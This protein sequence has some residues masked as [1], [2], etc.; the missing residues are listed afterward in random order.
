LLTGIRVK[1]II[2]LGLFIVIFAG[3]SKNDHAGERE[4]HNPADTMVAVPKPPGTIRIMSY[5]I[6]HGEGMDGKVDLYRIADVIKSSGADI[7]SLNEVDRNYSS[8][9]SYVDQIAWL[10]ENLDM[11]Y[12]FQATTINQASGSEPHEH[13]HA[14]LS[15]FP[16]ISVIKHDFT[17]YDEWHRG[18]METK[19]KINPDTLS[20]YVTHWGLD[21]SERLSQ[22]QE[23]LDWMGENEGNKIIAGDFNATPGSAEIIT[24]RNRFHGAFDNLPNVY[25]YNSTAP[26]AQ[27]DYFFGSR[28]IEFSNS[29]AIRTLAS[30]HLPIVSDVK[31]NR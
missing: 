24:V 7:I 26:Y 19:I 15:K 8:R 13:G 18:M 22:A 31:L 29:K 4:R 27:I 20:F 9:S 5:N 21:A 30:D 25:T 11:N 16:I 2:L 1:I 6:R 12:D 23:T 14:L 3:C 28:Q 17:A 10:A